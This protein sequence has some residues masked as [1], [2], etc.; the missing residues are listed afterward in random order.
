MKRNIS[1]MSIVE[2]LVS[3]SI[4][5]FLVLTVSAF[6]S[7]Q[8]KEI[9]RMTRK[10]E[11]IYAQNRISEV[12]QQDSFCQF[13]MNDASMGAF[14]NQSTLDTTAIATQKIILQ[15]IPFSSDAAAESILQV[16]QP[17]SDRYP[18]FLVKSIEIANFKGSGDKY[19]AELLLDFED[20]DSTKLKMKPMVIPLQISL[21]PTSP[22]NAKVILSCGSSRKAVNCID[23][24]GTIH[25]V[26][27]QCNGY[28]G[29]I[30]G[31]KITHGTSISFST[32]VINPDFNVMIFNSG[33]PYHNWN[34]DPP[35]LFTTSDQIFYVRTRINVDNAAVACSGSGCSHSIHCNTQRGWRLSSCFGNASG[36]ENDVGYLRDGCYSNDFFDSD[37]K[38]INILCAKNL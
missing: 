32:E 31:A 21:L 37:E 23:V 34:V 25:P 18:Q 13:L 16:N 11:A 28:V 15:K 9:Q 27:G 12:I 26:S 36:D 5:T 38:S 22:N 3:L 33:S 20:T 8:Q 7:E 1:G 35:L 29:Q 17:L 14:R 2:V 4:M 6:F 10:Q 19:I 24:G 30:V